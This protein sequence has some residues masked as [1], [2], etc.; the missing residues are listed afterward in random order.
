MARPVKEPLTKELLEKL[1]AD[2]DKNCTLSNVHLVT[3][4]LLAFAGFLRFD[5]LVQLWPCDRDRWKHGQAEGSDGA[6]PTSYE[7][8]MKC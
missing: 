4:C 3:A 8:G 2:T 7:R 6:N 1:V 5:E